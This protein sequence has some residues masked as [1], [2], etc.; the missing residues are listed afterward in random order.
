MEHELRDETREPLTE[1]RR[2]EGGE[3]TV[4]SSAIASTVAAATPPA[5]CVTMSRSGR[6]F[7]AARTH[8]SPIRRVSA[9]ERFTACAWPATPTSST[10]CTT[11]TRSAPPPVAASAE[12]IGSGA[13][14]D[15]S[16]FA[17]ALTH[18]SRNCAIGRDSAPARESSSSDA[19]MRRR[20]RIET[21]CPADAGGAMATSDARGR[22]RSTTASPGFHGSPLWN[23]SRAITRWSASSLENAVGSDVVTPP[24][25][26]K[27]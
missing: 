3:H 8:S 5:S 4:G 16:M 12:S 26:E 18:A 23:A 10:S 14:P 24:R 20:L 17:R 21:T 7:A 25:T 22:R 27:S 11:T 6:S 9:I 1:R 13:L 19:S 15:T 2:R